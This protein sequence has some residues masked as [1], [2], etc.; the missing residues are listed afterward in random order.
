MRKT[1]LFYVA[2]LTALGCGCTLRLNDAPDVAGDRPHLRCAPEE[3]TWSDVAAVYDGTE[4]S[5]HELITCGGMQIRLTQQLLMMI[6]ASN[7][8]LL[9]PGEEA[10][11]GEFIANP[12]TRNADGTWGMEIPDSPTSSFTLSFYEP[13]RDALITDDVFDMN[14]YLAGV[15]VQSTLGF[16]EMLQNP[17]KKNVF[18]YTYDGPGPLGHL[19]NDGEPLPETFELSLS[20]D[21][22]LG[23][24]DPFGGFASEPGPPANYGPFDSVMNVR[25]ESLVSYDDE[26]YVGGVTGDGTVSVQYEVRTRRDSVGHVAASAALDFDVERITGHYRD[27]TAEGDASDL[28]FV[29]TGVLAGQI[30]YRVQNEENVHIQ[31]TSDFGEGAAYP[32][33]DWSCPATSAD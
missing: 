17:T 11:V 28:R 23:T 3:P 24:L 19:M 29:S 12:F 33:A 16:L 20:L 8:E 26:Q 1:A 5:V 10:F 25:V 22:M 21:D 7:K 15:H 14:S 31:V 9:K 18:T 27:V 6:V 32:E 30:H 4:G 13:D 2:A